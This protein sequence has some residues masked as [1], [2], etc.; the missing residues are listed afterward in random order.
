[1]KIVFQPGNDDEGYDWESIKTQM[2]ILDDWS[3]GDCDYVDQFPSS[4]CECQD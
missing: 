2:Q 3:R 1:M 4:T